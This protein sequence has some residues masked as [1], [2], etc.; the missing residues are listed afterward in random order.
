MYRPTKRFDQ[1][2]GIND[3]LGDLQNLIFKPFKCP[4]IYKELGIEPPKGRLYF[5]KNRFIVNWSTWNWKNFNC[6]CNS[7][8]LFFIKLGIRCCFSKI[9]R[10]CNIINKI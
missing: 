1:I 9:N 10:S 8:S 6:K 3:I 4:E 7:W 5:I 2:G